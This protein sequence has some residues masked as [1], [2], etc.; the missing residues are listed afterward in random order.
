MSPYLS[1]NIIIVVIYLFSLSTLKDH[2]IVKWI[3]IRKKKEKNIYNHIAQE[4]GLLGNSRGGFQ[5]FLFACF[6]SSDT[7]DTAN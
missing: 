3:S 6:H 1:S 5:T 4:G 2:C 7:S